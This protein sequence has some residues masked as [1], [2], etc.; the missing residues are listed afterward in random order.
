M[1]GR[2]VLIPAAVAAIVACA[3]AFDL[4]YGTDPDMRPKPPVTISAKDRPPTPVVPPAV[5]K[6]NVLL[7]MTDDM[8]ADDVRWMPRTQRFFARRGT[9]FRNSF[10]PTPLCCPNRA[11]FL[12]GQYAHNHNVWWHDEPWGYGAFDDSRTLGNAL[13]DAGY[14]TGYVGKYLNR[15]GV[16]APKADPTAVP[17]TYVPTGWDDW[18]ATP[19]SVPLPT[20]HP[21]EG[22]TYNYFDTTVNVNG[23]LEGHQGAY[24]STVLVD[25]TLEM[26]DGFQQTDQPWYLQLNSLAPHHGGPVESDDPLDPRL[27]SPARP[28][29]V[30]GRFDAEIPRGLGI[31]ANGE[32]ERNVRDKARLTRQLPP[33]TA[34]D[35]EGLRSL[36]RQRA[37]SLLAF[38]E[39]LARILRRLH[40]DGELDR[41]IV[42]LTSDNGFL[43]GEHRWK[44]G[45]VIGYEPSYRV[46]LLVAG[47]GVPQGG[48]EFMPVTTVDLTSSV[49]DWTDAHLDGTDGRS[50]VDRLGKDGGWD[51]AIGYEAFLPSVRARPGVPGFEPNGARAIGVRTPEYF[52]VRYSNGQ[53][54]LFDLR[55]DPLEMV[56]VARD[57]AYDG[58]KVDLARLWEAFRAC[59]GDGCDV[60]LPP[61]LATDG[62]TT[63]ALTAA[64]EAETAR[65]YGG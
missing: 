45:K 2:R 20:W 26:L 27:A 9:D 57:T 11:S 19:D 4:A 15:Y 22:S 10:A 64:M 7:V 48:R 63:R 1:A 5:E 3:L 52:Y 65:Y 12:I 13:Q 62:A 47:P 31:P 43:Q 8:R 60:P 29:W 18:R 51:R 34:T 24:N 38:D 44:S 23:T 58:V 28:D 41:T 32:P 50:F 54:E 37:E 39:E 42:A 30:K 16:A 55:R 61:G 14:R 6:P 56:S 35:L 36:S 53:E 25:E 49:L 17:H 33:L 21:L 40:R 46:P 59:R